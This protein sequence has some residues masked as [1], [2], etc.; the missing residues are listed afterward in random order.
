MEI[1]PV[2]ISD[3]LVGP[4]HPTFLVAE[5]G[6]NH[7]G[8]IG[9]AKALID[10][11]AKNNFDAVKFQK[12]TVE[13]VYTPEELAQPRESPFGTTNGDLKRH[14]EFGVDEYREIDRYCKEKRI[15]WYASPW[16]PVSVD[17]LERFDPPCYKVASACLTDHALLKHIKSKGKPVIMSTGM[18]TLEEIDADVE[19]LDGVPLILLHCNSTYPCPDADVNLAVID[20]LRQRYLRC[21]GYSGHEVSVPPSLMAVVGFDACMV[22]RHITLNRAMWGTDHPASLEPRGVE[23]LAKYIRT[24]P[25]VRGDGKKQLY[26][27]EIPVRNKLRRVR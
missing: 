12:R 17:F 14:L 2:R 8:D 23:L 19:V 16:D 11:A 15:L 24:W 25:K 6:I 7:N 20:T 10:L 1:Q 9:I 22:E 4:G 21:V 13:L 5:I 27:S 3:K 26:S 18:S